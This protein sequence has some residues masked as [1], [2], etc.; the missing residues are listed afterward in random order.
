M[1]HPN[2][3]P[4]EEENRRRELHRQGLDDWAIAN[5]V[6]VKHRSIASWRYTRGLKANRQKIQRSQV[7]PGLTESG[8]VS[9]CTE[10]NR[11]FIQAFERDLVSIAGKHRG[12][13]IDVYA[14]IRIWR[15]VRADEVIAEI[16]GSMR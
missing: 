7:L 1:R 10:A 4:I 13:P 12:E 5:A 9:R 3:L 11:L 8:V 15:E 16:E 14:F 2:C 6:G